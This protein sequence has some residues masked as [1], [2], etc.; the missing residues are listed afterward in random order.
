MDMQPLASHLTNRRLL[1]DA[2]L[3]EG[4]KRS[5]SSHKKH[6]CFSAKE[7]DHLERILLPFYVIIKIMTVTQS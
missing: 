3:G 2:T 6:L 4:K 1:T 5:A 7:I